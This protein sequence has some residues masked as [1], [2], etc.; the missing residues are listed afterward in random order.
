MA[1][2]SVFVP[3]LAIEELICEQ[4]FEREQFAV[5]AD[6]LQA[7]GEPLG[8][9]I[10]L[11]IA[12][13]TRED[14]PLRAREEKFIRERANYLFDIVGEP[15]TRSDHK[16]LWS[17]REMTFALRR[18]FVLAV[19]AR[20]LTNLQRNDYFAAMHA[21]ALRL[22]NWA[23]LSAT[24]DYSMETHAILSESPCARSLIGLTIFGSRFDLPRGLP[25]LKSL[26]LI[27]D[28]DPDSVS[29]TLLSPLLEQLEVLVM[30]IDRPAFP[31]IQGASGQLAHLKGISIICEF[32]DAEV[33]AL[34]SIAGDR[35]FACARDGEVRVISIG[36]ADYVK[37]MQAV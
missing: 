12:L 1:G 37:K 17:A 5:Y 20:V 32:Q 3:N 2:V 15:P 33:E 24:D 14:E 28:G 21:P 26:T 6:W 36:D 10:A 7:K 31:V 30:T 11:Q 23:T 29:E 16:W 19:T 22:V 25:R 18:G 27:D 9:L 34:R 4:P 13:E 8:E 35:D